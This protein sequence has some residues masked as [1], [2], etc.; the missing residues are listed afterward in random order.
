MAS[1]AALD[2]PKSQ[3]RRP[4]GPVEI[5]CLLNFGAIWPQAPLMMRRR[6]SR[7]NRNQHEFNRGLLSPSFGRNQNEFK[8]GY[9]G[10]A[11]INTSWGTNGIPAAG[12]RIR[13]IRGAPLSFP[14]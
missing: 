6:H 11:R 3:S 4:P 1:A 2:D 14:V 7:V 13:D 10:Y 5:W 9:R 8:R 12:T